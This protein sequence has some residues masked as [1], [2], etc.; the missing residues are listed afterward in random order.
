MCINSLIT[1]EWRYSW[2]VHTLLGSALRNAQMISDGFEVI[3]R[4]LSAGFEYV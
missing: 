2:Q 1:K 4:N 3:E